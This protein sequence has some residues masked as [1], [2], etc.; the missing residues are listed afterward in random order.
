MYERAKNT[1]YQCIKL[2]VRHHMSL[3]VFT[4]GLTFQYIPCYVCIFAKCWNTPISTN[5][6]LYLLILT[7]PPFLFSRPAVSTSVKPGARHQSDIK[8]GEKLKSFQRQYFGNGCSLK[9]W[10]IRSSHCISIFPFSVVVVFHLLHTHTQINKKFNSLIP[11]AVNLAVI[12]S[13]P[14]CTCSTFAEPE[15]WSH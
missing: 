11:R 4:K 14:Q 5:L 10:L 12:L 9:Y 7:L 3:K 1:Y 8:S 2:N 6:I 13:S 15:L